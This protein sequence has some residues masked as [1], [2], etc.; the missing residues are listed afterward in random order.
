M[1]E[2]PFDACD[3]IRHLPELLA[4][5]EPILET[6]AAKRVLKEDPVAQ[7]AL[8]AVADYAGAYRRGRD[9]VWEAR[10]TYEPTIEKPVKEAERTFKTRLSNVLM[11]HG[12]RL[13]AE[14]GSTDRWC[15]LERSDPP[16][17]ARSLNQLASSLS[18]GT[19]AFETPLSLV[20][21]AGSSTARKAPLHRARQF[22]LGA[23]R[24]NVDSRRAEFFL[25][26]CGDYASS[27]VTSHDWLGFARGSDVG[28]LSAYCLDQA[29]RHSATSDPEKALHLA[30]EACRT[31]RLTSPIRYNILLYA[32]MAG[33]RR[34]AS[35][36]ADKTSMSASLEDTSP[37]VHRQIEFDRPHWKRVRI[38]YPSLFSD[39]VGTL[40]ALGDVVSAAAQS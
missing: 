3:L 4:G 33:N 15:A 19:D 29:A 17:S 34:I 1:N 21:S 13:V 40:G 23:R 28:M 10:R 20:D 11:T 14:G 8:L 25:M 36:F 16:D 39:V 6:P 22:L 7:A 31:I 38:E 2:R 18:I 30:L 24:L 12:A 27:S 26:A 35:E 32:S 37:A 9:A 5:P